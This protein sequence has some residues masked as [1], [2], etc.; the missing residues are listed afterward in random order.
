MAKSDRTPGGPNLQIGPAGLGIMVDG[1]EHFGV[2][3]RQI[4]SVEDQVQKSE[5]LKYRADFAKNKEK[6]RG[7]DY[8]PLDIDLQFNPTTPHQSTLSRFVPILDG[9]AWSFD[10]KEYDKALKDPKNERPYYDTQSPARPMTYVEWLGAAQSDPN[11]KKQVNLRHATVRES[12]RHAM[13]LPF[14]RDLYTIFGEEHY[15]AMQKERVNNYLN[16]W[17]ARD[18]DSFNQ[19][20]ES[21]DA[22]IMFSPRHTLTDPQQK[23]L[24]HLQSEHFG[25][26]V[27][28]Y[29]EAKMDSAAAVWDLFSTVVGLKGLVRSAAK[30]LV[31]GAELA[32]EGG[33]AASSVWSLAKGNAQAGL[34][35]L[36]TE[37]ANPENVEEG[38][39]LPFV[40]FNTLSRHGIHDYAERDEYKKP[41]EK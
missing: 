25:M 29:A 24:L 39:P 1:R 41:E 2:P 16:E 11:L 20:V 32:A 30:S 4:S 13:R 23:R 33:S 21:G 27:Y 37:E 18:P 26:P 40:T 31:K 9:H 19:F 3:G 5:Y 22:Y 15:A 12:A 17:Y 6:V 14:A 35:A 28:G 8:K 7:L 38:S 34:A 10:Q 36:T